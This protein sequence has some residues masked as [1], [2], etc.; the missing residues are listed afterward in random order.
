VPTSAAV[1]LSTWRQLL[2]RSTVMKCGKGEVLDFIV[3]S[4]LI[5]FYWH[6]SRRAYEAFTV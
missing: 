5:S 1:G 6:E 4:T 2:A 3:I